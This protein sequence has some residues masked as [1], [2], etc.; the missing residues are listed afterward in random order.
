M[1][2]TIRKKLNRAGRA[3]WEYLFSP[4][5][6][7]DTGKRRWISKSGFLTQ[8]EAQEAMDKARAKYRDEPVA[9]EKKPMPTFAEFYE[10]FHSEVV[11]RHKGRKTSE[12]EYELAQYAVR[13]FGAAPLDQLSAE[14]LTTDVN[15]LLDHGGEITKAQPE[16]KPLSPTTV[17]HICF[18]AQ[19]CLQQAVDWDIITKNPMKKVRKPKRVKRDPKVVDSGAFD[20]LLAVVA[21]TAL[22][23]PIVVDNAT[24]IRRGELCALEWTDLDWDRATISISKSLGQLQKG[25][26]YLKCTKSTRPRNFDLSAVVV[27]I[28]LA[29]ERNQ[30]Q[31]RADYGS[32]YIDRNLI[33]A[34]PDGEYYSPKHL[35]ERISAAMRRAGIPK[36]VSLHSLRHSH[37]SQLLSDGVPITVV[38]ERLGHANANITLGIYAHAMPNDSKVAAQRWND[39]M[40]DV[41]ERN[42]KASRARKC[43][44]LENVGKNSGQISVIP[45]KSAS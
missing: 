36:G 2:G 40:Q 39:S 28:L 31:E 19:A 23:A 38:S 27:D 32:G 30:E 4:G 41:I 25:E 11:K 15:W 3:R 22:F 44:R 14:Q 34:R 13:R 17:R 45:I 16:G 7:P 42:L 43:E 37:A 24:G 21:G 8:K 10:R 20:R 12:R 9:E 18:A 29:H 1:K 5:I 33:F 26:T 6:N 35:S